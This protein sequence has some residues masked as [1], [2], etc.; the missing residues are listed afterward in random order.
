MAKSIVI[1]EGAAWGSQANEG[2]WGDFE[3]PPGTQKDFDA[4]YEKLADLVV[5]RFEAIAQEHGHVIAWVPEMAQVIGPMG[6]DERLIAQLDS[7]RIEA[8]REIQ[9]KW[10]EGAI[11]AVYATG[12]QTIEP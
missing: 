8:Q 3:V 6:S 1:A 7:W 12:A 9:A 4:T 10:Q 2:L 11:A 5:E